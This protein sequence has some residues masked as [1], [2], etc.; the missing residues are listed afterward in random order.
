MFRDIPPA[1]AIA[2]V[3]AAWSHGIRSFDTA[4]FY[5]AGLAEMRLGEALA[6]KPR[7]D[8]V[9]ST[10]VGRPCPRRPARVGVHEH[11]RRAPQRDEP[12]RAR[13]SIDDPSMTIENSDVKARGSIP[14][15]AA[16][17]LRGSRWRGEAV[18]RGKSMS[19]LRA[20]PGDD[21]F[22]YIVELF[23]DEATSERATAVVLEVVSSIEPIPRPCQ[24]KVAD[25][26]WAD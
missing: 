13:R 6:G 3:E 24:T 10:K 20:F 23:T 19:V 18:E 15:R 21:R 22:L 11:S 17:G 16:G 8:Y 7:R 4:P 26:F 5:G 25:S 14:L 1:D 9:L 12:R 2:T